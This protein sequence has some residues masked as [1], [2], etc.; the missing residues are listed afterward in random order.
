MARRVGS[1]GSRLSVLAGGKVASKAWI[2]NE[3]LTD[4]RGLTRFICAFDADGPGREATVEIIKR[5]DGTAA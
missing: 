5:F 4:W 2:A 3:S 1:T